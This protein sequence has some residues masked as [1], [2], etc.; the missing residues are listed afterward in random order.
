MPPKRCRAQGISTL[1]RADHSRARLEEL[2]DI[3]CD[4]DDVN[5]QRGQ[6]WDLTTRLKVLGL[7]KSTSPAH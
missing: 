1:S 4:T 6:S 7:L 2:Y 5:E 3:L